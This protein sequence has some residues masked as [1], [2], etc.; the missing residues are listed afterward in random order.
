MDRIQ[1]SDFSKLDIRV[2]KV[3]AAEAV[4]E[5]DDL[6]RMEIDIGEDEKRQIVAGMKQYYQPEDLVG[7]TV[8]VLINLEPKKIRGHLSDGMILAAST[9]GYEEV[10]LL[11]VDGNLPPG[12][13]IS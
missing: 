5:A 1:Y 3:I 12:C 4:P 6:I 11:S 9:P 7:R 10:K 2:G 8:V 13:K